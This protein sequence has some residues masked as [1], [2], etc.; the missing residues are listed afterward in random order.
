[1]P[2]VGGLLELR[3]KPLA[4]IL[5]RGDGAVSL[6]PNYDQWLGK[7]AKTVDDRRNKKR[8]KR[9]VGRGLAMLVEVGRKRAIL[10]FSPSLYLL[11]YLSGSLNLGRK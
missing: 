10:I 7:Q 2:S 3:L 9:F 4:A 8:R 6:R 1:V 11:S 5:C